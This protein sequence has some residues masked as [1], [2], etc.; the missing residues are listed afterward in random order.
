[1]ADIQPSGERA[2]RASH[3]D[4]DRVAEILRVAAGD[5]RLDP[6]ELDER[7]ERALTAR[8]YAELAVLTTDLPATPGT[9]IAPASAGG[10]D[11]PPAKDLVRIHVGSGSARRDGGWVVPKE[12][13]VKVTSGGVRLDFTQAVI[14]QPLLRVTAEVRSGG[15]T[16]ITKPGV[17]VDVDDVTVRSG[18]VKVRAPW[19]HDV[20][21][22]LRVE[23]SGSVRSG[24]ITARP[25]RRSLWEWLRRAPRRYALPA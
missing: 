24:G 4:R 5:G 23:V 22:L 11:T 10:L 19:G 8:T 18:G 16:L 21:V 9:G 7:L 13:D 2:L 20:P 14:T 6:D 17:V 1:M 15:L 25:P 12:L 3:E